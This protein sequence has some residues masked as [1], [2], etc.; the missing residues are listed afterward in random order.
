MTNTNML[1][2][3]VWEIGNNK[4]SYFDLEQG[5]SSLID[6]M[7]NYKGI[8]SVEQY[9]TY[10][11]KDLKLIYEND[12]LENKQWN[13]NKCIVKFM[14]GK[15]CLCDLESGQYLA[16]IDI[17]EDSTGCDFKIISNINEYH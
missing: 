14:F 6:E 16:D 3:R 2:F 5:L 11:D 12:I 8:G 15:F 4:Y 7:T 1:K 17:I 9:T 13:P 10:K